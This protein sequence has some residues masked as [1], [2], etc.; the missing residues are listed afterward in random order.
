MSRIGLAIVV[1]LASLVAPCAAQQRIDP[2]VIKQ[3]LKDGRSVEFYA[4][5]RKADAEGA[6]LRGAS[7]E[8]AMKHKATAPGA[9]LGEGGP[10]ASGGDTESG[11]TAIAQQLSLPLL[12][13][14]LCMMGAAYFNFVWRDPKTGAVGNRRVAVILGVAGA[15]L[16]LWHL[17]P[18][19][20]KVIGVVVGVGLAAAWLY[21]EVRHPIIAATLEKRAKTSF[22]T[23]R[24]LVE[25]IETAPASARDQVKTVFKE[26]A[27]D[28]E[29]Q[30]HYADVKRAD[31][32]EKSV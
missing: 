8:V 2:E 6:S 18:T 20:G 32:P 11:L 16:I 30:K 17:V 23:V 14:V 28:P 29:D 25:A 19:W 10:S 31:F 26:T 3:A 7:D 9:N 21:L 15:G 22:E 24:G 27:G 13:G 12:L 1:C 5:D 4:R